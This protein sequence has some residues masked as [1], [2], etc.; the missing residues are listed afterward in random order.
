MS[1]IFSVVFHAGVYFRPSD[2]PHSQL[3]RLFLPLHKTR[4]HSVNS[5]FERM[6]YYCIVVIF[7]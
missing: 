5:I 7:L 2:V 1:A 6:T 3:F 4:W